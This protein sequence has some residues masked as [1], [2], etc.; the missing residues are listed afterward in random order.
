[1]GWFGKRDKAD[2]WIPVAIHIVN[3]RRPSPHSESIANTN[4]GALIEYIG[5]QA[6]VPYE[7]VLEVRT[8]DA[9]PYRVTQKSKV[10]V[11]VVS[12]GLLSVEVKIP[13][14]VDVGGWA[15]K[16]D[17]TTVAIDWT[18]YRSTPEG[19][20]VVEDARQ[21]DI[22]LKYA[23]HVVAKATPAMQA[24]LRNSAWTSTQ[25]L[26]EVVASGALSLEVWEGE[27]KSNL[28]KTLITAE[29]YAEA[30]AVAKRSP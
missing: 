17:P 26:A 11:K 14:G 28:R 30:A 27:A 24:K 10:P 21:V 22:D 13:N 2:D 1:M 9:E 25:S 3:A 5:D 4:L 15:R 8:P 6:G 23:E 12:P 16:D 19:V 18:S 29:Q 7:F 20:A